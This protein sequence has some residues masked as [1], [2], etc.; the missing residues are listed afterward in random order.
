MDS[1]FSWHHHKLLPVVGKLEQLNRVLSKYGHRANS[2]TR[3]QSRTSLLEKLVKNA[4]K[5]VPKTLAS[6]GV[7]VSLLAH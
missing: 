2:S 3:I 5:I 7:D 6:V 1:I 4:P